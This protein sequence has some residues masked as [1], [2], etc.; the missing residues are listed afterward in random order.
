MGVGASN[1]Y[2][3]HYADRAGDH[4]QAAAKVRRR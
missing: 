1:L 2:S 4:T 3:I